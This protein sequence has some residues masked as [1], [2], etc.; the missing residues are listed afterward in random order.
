MRLPDSITYRLARYISRHPTRMTG[1]RAI[2]SFTFDDF[3]K[4]AA[5]T[6]AR[7]LEDRG[8]R[9]SFFLTSGYEGRT[10][11]G[12]PQFDADDLRRLLD[13]GHEIGCHTARHPRLTT[14]SAAQV[15]AE[16]ADSAHQL[17]QIAGRPAKPALAYPFGDVSSRVKRIAARHF[18]AGRGVWPGLNE[19]R[20]DR[21]LLKCV[22]LED[23]ILAQRSAEEWI[24]L[25]VA[26]SAW[27]IFLTHD[28]DERPTPFG[29]T[30]A[31]LQRIVDHACAADADILPLSHALER[32]R[33]GAGRGSFL[34][35]L[36][37]FAFV[38]GDQVS[39]ITS[40]IALLGNAALIGG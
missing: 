32:C 10:I 1:G 36:A 23:H 28:V 39:T 31:A 8:L 18:S 4:S 40:A 26:R 34:A 3:P 25:A 27:L 38:G 35:S 30:P 7:I 24:D 13:A 17:Q 16:L 33:H 5:T 22:C 12:V 6:G 29:I 19:G 2:I 20:F 11:D 15:E 21:M 37:P 9:G 14:L